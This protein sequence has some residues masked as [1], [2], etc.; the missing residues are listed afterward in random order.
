ME[1]FKKR[2]HKESLSYEF[3]ITHNLYENAMDI[4]E[5]F[6]TWVN[7]SINLS[8]LTFCLY[9]NSLD[10]NLICITTKSYLLFWE[11][12][13]TNHMIGALRVLKNGFYQQYFK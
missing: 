11:N 6:N 10:Q 9:I 1:N 7:S 8:E 4:D 12:N 5:L 13:G 2:L 3:D